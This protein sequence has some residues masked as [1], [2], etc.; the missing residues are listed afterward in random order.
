MN[1]KKKLV[2]SLTSL[3]IVLVVAIAAVGITLAA[4]TGTID[5]TFKITYTAYNVNATVTATYKVGELGSEEKFTGGS[6]GSITFTPDQ[7]SATGTLSVTEPIT[8]DT[9]N[10][11]V[12]VTYT[13]KNNWN[14]EDEKSKLVVTAA[15]TTITGGRWY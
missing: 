4:L 9:T 14:D 10:N 12:V 7:E 3:A 13:F 15:P 1:T 5:S 8:L 6:E 2:I 11:F